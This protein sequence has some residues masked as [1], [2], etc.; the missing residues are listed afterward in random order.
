MIFFADLITNT[1]FHMLLLQT[2]DDDDLI[3]DGNVFKSLHE[4][5]S[6]REV[7]IIVQSYIY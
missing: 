6:K 7:P 3:P 4:S 2:K 1:I 5:S